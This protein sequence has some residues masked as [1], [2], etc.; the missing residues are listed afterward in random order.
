M[1]DSYAT[2]SD[3]QQNLTPFKHECYLQFTVRQLVLFIYELNTPSLLTFTPVNLPVKH[4]ISFM[5]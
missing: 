3:S 1:V 5:D 2:L 4:S